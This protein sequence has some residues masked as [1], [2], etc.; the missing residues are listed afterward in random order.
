MDQNNTP[1]SNHEAFPNLPTLSLSLSLSLLS[2]FLSLL[3]SISFT[4]FQ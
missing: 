1:I 3:L 2:L 4:P